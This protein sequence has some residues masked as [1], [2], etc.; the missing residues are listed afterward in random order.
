MLGE[1]SGVPAAVKAELGFFFP[2]SVLAGLVLGSLLS[3]FLNRSN[4]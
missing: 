3:P 2:E 4:V 1:K